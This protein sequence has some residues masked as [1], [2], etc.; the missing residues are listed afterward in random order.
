MSTGWA[1]PNTA[2][3]SPSAAPGELRQMPPGYRVPDGTFSSGVGGAQRRF[4]AYDV[5]VPAPRP[6]RYGPE[7]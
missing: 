4:M 1:T 7:P 2:P 5:A 3:R 6:V